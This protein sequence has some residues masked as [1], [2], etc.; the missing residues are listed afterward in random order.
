MAEK[1]FG[2]LKNGNLHGA[3][4]EAMA[5]FFKGHHLHRDAIGPQGRRHGF[6]LL[7]WHQLVFESLEEDHRTLDLVG[8]AER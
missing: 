3:I 7:G 2:G 1:G 6:G 4:P 5:F 8:M